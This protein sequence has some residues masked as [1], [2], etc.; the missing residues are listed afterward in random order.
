M[1]RKRQER[2]HLC[3]RVAGILPAVKVSTGTDAGGTQAKMPAIL[4]ESS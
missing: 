4:S 2:T 3:V 1:L